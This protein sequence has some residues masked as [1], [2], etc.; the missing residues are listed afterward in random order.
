MAS[1]SSNNPDDGD[2]LMLCDHKP[3]PFMGCACVG[4]ERIEMVAYLLKHYCEVFSGIL[5]IYVGL[6]FLWIMCRMVA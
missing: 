4:V 5:Y 2:C 1:N 3:Y 6:R